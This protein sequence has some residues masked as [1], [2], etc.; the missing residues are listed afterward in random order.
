MGQHHFIGNTKEYDLRTLYR[1]KVLERLGYHPIFISRLEERND[2]T[3]YD[4]Y[5]FREIAKLL[6]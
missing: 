5:L 2:S 6:E 1:K 3:S 4:I